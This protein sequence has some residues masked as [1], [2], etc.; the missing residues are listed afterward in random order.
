MWPKRAF[1]DQNFLPHSV[2]GR[3]ILGAAGSGLGLAGLVRAVSESI[4]MK[5]ERRFF[6]EVWLLRTRVAAAEEELVSPTTEEDKERGWLKSDEE[7][8]RLSMLFVISISNFIN[9][10][11]RKKM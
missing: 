1:H 2:Q 11:E 7:G 6:L 5:L 8:R 3:V 4:V 10:K 9:R